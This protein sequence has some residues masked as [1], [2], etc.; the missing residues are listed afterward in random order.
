MFTLG[1]QGITKTF[2]TVA[3]LTTVDTKARKETSLT[4]E[5]SVNIAVTVNQPGL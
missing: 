3:E 5:E 4:K 1:R 2:A